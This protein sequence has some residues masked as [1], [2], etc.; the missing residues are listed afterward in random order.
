M[1]FW[2]RISNICFHWEN[3]CLGWQVYCYHSVGCSSWCSPGVNFLRQKWL[4]L[5]LV[6]W[7]SQD[8]FPNSARKWWLYLL[9][10]SV[11]HLC[12]IFRLSLE[13]RT[14]GFFTWYGLLFNFLKKF[15]RFFLVVCRNLRICCFVSG[16]WFVAF[17]L[18]K[19]WYIFYV[20]SD[21]HE[22]NCIALVHI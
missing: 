2:T 5:L 16:R 10:V 3:W 18:K 12:M 14:S 6:A 21:V 7:C 17:I 1:Q 15:K 8:I 13:F 20:I 19:I 4:I 11:V 22:C 9:F